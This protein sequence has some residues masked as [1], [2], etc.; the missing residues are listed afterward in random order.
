MAAVTRQPGS[1][2][3]APG[4]A[5]RRRACAGAGSAR[6][7]RR[8]CSVLPIVPHRHPR[9]LV[10]AAEGR[11]DVTGQ[12]R[13]DA[14]PHRLPRRRGLRARARERVPVVRGRVGDAAVPQLRVQVLLQRVVE[15]VREPR[16]GLLAGETAAAGAVGGRRPLVRLGLRDDAPVVP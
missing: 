8:Q 16:G 6:R 12:A 14:A 3:V 5:G 2:E 10:A 4:R 13:L 11:A 7:L 9:H 15:G 1:P